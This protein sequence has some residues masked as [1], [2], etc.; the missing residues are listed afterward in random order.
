VGHSVAG[1]GDADGDGTPDIVIGAPTEDS[2]GNLA[3]SAY[4]VLGRGL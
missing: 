4:L 1:G 3:G 2:G